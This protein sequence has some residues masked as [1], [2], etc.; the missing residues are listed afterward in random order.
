MDNYIIVNAD[1]IQ[2][3]IDELKKPIAHYDGIYVSDEQK[4]RIDELEELLSNS[5]LLIPEIEKAFDIGRD[6]NYQNISSDGGEHFESINC[7]I[8]KEDCISQLKLTI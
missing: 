2:K 1:T 5:I 3:R 4:A 8:S 7:Q 6:D